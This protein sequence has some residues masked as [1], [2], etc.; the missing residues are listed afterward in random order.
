M[1]KNCIRTQGRASLSGELPPKRAVLRGIT[2]EI[3]RALNSLPEA[4][5]LAVWF[6]LRVGLDDADIAEI[7]RVSERDVKRLTEQGISSIAAALDRKAIT[8][9]ASSLKTVISLIPCERMPAAMFSCMASALAEGG[10]ETHQPTKEFRC[11]RG[12]GMN[13]RRR[14]PFSLRSGHDRL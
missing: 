11:R 9:D 6:G 7:V 1:M 10:K 14:K 12:S 13:M 4:H 3:S 8:T 5:R 2:A